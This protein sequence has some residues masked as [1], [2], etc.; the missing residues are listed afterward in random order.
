M[1]TE[2]RIKNLD[3]QD[4]QGTFNMQKMDNKAKSVYKIGSF[5]F[6]IQV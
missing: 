2:M 6:H 1:A 4:F 5:Q 3:E